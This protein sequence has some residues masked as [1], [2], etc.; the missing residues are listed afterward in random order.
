M[1]YSI[2]DIGSNTIILNIFKSN[3]NNEIKRV[4]YLDRTVGLRNYK[5]DDIL[6]DNGIKK[7]IETLNYYKEISKDF[8]IDKIMPFATASLRKLE[9]LEE[10]LERVKNETDLE[11]DVITGEKEAD[12]GF[13]GTTLGYEVENGYILDIGGGSTEITLIKNAEKG[14]SKSLDIGHLSLFNDYVENI[15]VNKEELSKIEKSVDNTLKDLEITSLENS[16]IYGVGGTVDA[17]RKLIKNKYD[18]ED[19]IPVDIFNKYYNYIKNLDK[20]VY[21]EI[22]KITPERIHT[23]VVGM[24]ILKG[25]IDKLKPDYLVPSDTGLREGYLINYLSKSEEE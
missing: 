25:Y 16:K 4:L 7:L 14:F 6:S 21:M 19:E 5:K 8:E 11:I 12:L 18:I 20:E 17:V 15:L 13:T 10:V 1:K 3:D 24:A 22:L 23:I 2:I 9:N